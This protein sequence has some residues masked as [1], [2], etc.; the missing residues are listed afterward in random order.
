M[1]GSAIHRFRIWQVTVSLLC[2]FLLPFHCSSI[3]DEPAAD[4]NI[5]VARLVARLGSESF[6]ERQRAERELAKLGNGSRRELEAATAS[7]DAEVRLRAGGLLR[8]LKLSEMWLPSL[9]EYHSHGEL[10]ADAITAI[11]QQT[12]NRILIGDSYGTF[13]NRLAKID[14]EAGAYWQVIDDL[15]RSTGNRARLHYDT[16]EPGIVLVAGDLGHFPTAYAGPLR[17]QVN[18]AVRSFNEKLDYGDL[19][20]QKSHTFELEISVLWEDRFHLVAYRPQPSLI[21]AVTD[22]GVSLNCAQSVASSWI[23]TTPGTR[24]LSAKLN[25]TPPPVSA[26][27]LDRLEL[28]WGLT[29]VGDM[30]TLRVDDVSKRGIYHQD[31]LELTIDSV[32]RREGN[33]FDLTL[34]LARELAQPDPQDILFQ[35]YQAEL[36]DADGKS[37]TFQGQSNML[38]DRGAQIRY[39]FLADADDRQPKS[40]RLTYP[41]IRS[42]RDVDI[43]FHDV[44]LPT[45]RPD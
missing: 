24:Q 7:D 14:Y 42:Q 6:E 36:I 27:R 22:T 35:E 21:R 38:I 20:S 12:E 4:P 37:M 33:R 13:E 31:D 29:A 5:R 18:S 43:V 25:L 11:C 26:K 10:A 44:P 40:L 1:C 45:A 8:Q 3:A 39:T 41:R 23:V 9:I 16:R 28:R 2:F 32:E 15:C 30:A 34:V 17:A 19:A